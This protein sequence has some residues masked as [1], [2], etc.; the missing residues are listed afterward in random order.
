MAASYRDSSPQRM[1]SSFVCNPVIGTCVLPSIDEFVLQTS[2]APHSCTVGMVLDSNDFMS[3]HE[4]I[5]VF[6]G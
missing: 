6:L 2:I 5:V 3:E 4:E 1:L